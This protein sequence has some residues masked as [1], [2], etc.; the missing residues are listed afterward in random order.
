MKKG[1]LEGAIQ[2]YSTAFRVD[3]RMY[4]AL[5]ER[6]TLYV[7]QHKWEQAMA[8]FNTAL[9]IS[10]SFFLAAI[11]RAEVNQT[12]GH[13]DKALAELTH[14]I[15]LRPRY[16]TDALARSDRAWLYAACP[17]PAFRN[18]QQAVTDATAACKIDFWDSWDYIDTLAAAYA[19][20]GDFA[21]AIRFQEKAIRKAGGEDTKSSQARL[22]LYQQQR[23]YRFASAR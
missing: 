11:K 14:I 9:K 3:P 1:D 2:S 7:H 16:H 19:E 8:D 22:A 20:A 21:N 12:L 13:Y 4:V 15:N 18:G 10:P 23:P 5:Y 17:D 6:G